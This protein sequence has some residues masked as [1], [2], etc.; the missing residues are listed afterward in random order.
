[1]HCYTRLDTSVKPI[2]DK[3]KCIN[4]TEN[5]AQVPFV[6]ARVLHE[7]ILLLD[8][9]LFFPIGPQNCFVWP[10]T[11][12]YIKRTSVF[13]FFFQKLLRDEDYPQHVFQ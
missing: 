2:C 10:G 3:N 5:P 9:E 1:M 7:K 4:G 6:M 13:T 11:S 12:I 8:R